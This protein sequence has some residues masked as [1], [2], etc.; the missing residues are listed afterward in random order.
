MRLPT[1]LYVPLCAWVRCG[2]MEAALPLRTD[3][4]SSS[5]A[6][7]ASPPI[8]HVARAA[9]QSHSLIARRYHAGEHRQK[10]CESPPWCLGLHQ[11]R[12]S[13]SYGRGHRRSHAS[14]RIPMEPCRQGRRSRVAVA[15][16]DAIHTA[17]QTCD[18]RKRAR[19][20]LRPG[21]DDRAITHSRR[22]H[23]AAFA[24]A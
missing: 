3:P 8:E 23:D 17:L 20:H 11:A 14:I 16:A 7:H 1:L 6:A 22:P 18:W 5:A 13:H 2:M 24:D 4:R 19:A 10:C 9:D 12:W 21:D 15:F